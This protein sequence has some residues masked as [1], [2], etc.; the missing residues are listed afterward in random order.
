MDYVSI[1]PLCYHSQIMVKSGIQ[2][3]LLILKKLGSYSLLK[4]QINQF[5]DGRVLFIRRRKKQ[6]R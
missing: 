2:K 5:A 3:R 4:E 1:T 6:G